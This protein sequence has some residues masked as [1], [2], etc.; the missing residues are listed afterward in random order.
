M[1]TLLTSLCLLGATLCNAQEVKNVKS[2]ATS[3]T[4]NSDNI[5]TKVDVLPK[6][7]G[8]IKEFLKFTAENLKYP[9]Q[10]KKNGVQGRVFCKFIVE[11]DGALT[12]IEI[13]RGLGSGCDEE[14]LR[15]LNLSPKW[16]PGTRNGRPVR[17]SYVI[18]IMFQP[19]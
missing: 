5:Y 14:A 2:T 10:A 9:K 13:V 18:P 15:L 11:K 16:I 19:N 8:G 7:P 4:T 1:K 3:E 17:V 6:F 12:N